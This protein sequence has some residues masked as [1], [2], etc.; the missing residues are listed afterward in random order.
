MVEEKK[1]NRLKAEYEKIQKKHKLPSFKELNEDFWIEEIAEDETDLLIRKIR[2]KVGD[3]LSRAVRFVE[4]LLNPT[5][6]PM[7]VFSIVKMMD[8]ED[9]KKLSEMYK[10]LVKSEVRLIKLDFEFNEEKEAQFIINS[11]K[12][13]QPIKKELLEIMEKIDL[14]WDDK[15]ETN[16]K[17]YFG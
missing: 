7:F 15:A 6:A 10:D 17:G 11:Y 9:K 8:S 14:K 4:G 3:H 13:W 16:N 1:L 12:I 2:I 5:N